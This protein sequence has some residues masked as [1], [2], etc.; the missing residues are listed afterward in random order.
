M[1]FFL[2]IL[3]TDR[4]V[5][6]LGYLLII[7]LFRISVFIPAVFCSELDIGIELGRAPDYD[8]YQVN[9]DV[10]VKVMSKSEQ[11]VH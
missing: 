9:G 2:R 10:Y 6:I 11:M 1:Y 8:Y 5:L 7:L 4:F 3:F